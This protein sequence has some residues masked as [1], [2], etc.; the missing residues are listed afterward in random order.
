MM[1]NNGNPYM[2]MPIDRVRADALHG[3]RAAREA[4]RERDPDGAGQQLGK[5]IEPHSQQDPARPRRLKS[6]TMI[7]PPLRVAR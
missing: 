1:N 5:V 3:V 7:F 2:V 6:I 4:W